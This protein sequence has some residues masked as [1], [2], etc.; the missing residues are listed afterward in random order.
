MSKEKGEKITVY[1][2]PEI[3]EILEKELIGKLG[4]G[5]SETINLIL[6][7]YLAERG[8]LRL[9]DFYGRFEKGDKNSG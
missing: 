3:Y 6:A 5:K 1:V 7:I 8:Y 2:P 9:R 4:R